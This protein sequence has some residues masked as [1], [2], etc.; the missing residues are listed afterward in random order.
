MNFLRREW[1]K[2]VDDLWP[3]GHRLNGLRFHDLRHTCASL[4]LA[5]T[6]NLHV[7]KVRLG[8]EDIKTTVNRYGGLLESVDV[9]LADALGAMIANDEN[10]AEVVHL[11]AD[12]TLAR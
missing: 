2:T 12:K 5:A 8:H 1:R 10:T 4:S 6:G 3:Q 7:V 11:D 9:A